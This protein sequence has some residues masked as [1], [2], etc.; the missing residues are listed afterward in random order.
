MGFLDSFGSALGTAMKKVS[1][2]AQEINAY[3]QQYMGWSREEL[4]REIQRTSGNRQ[5][6]AMAAYKAMYGENK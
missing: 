5:M 2:K 3:K 6:G 1:E 4:R